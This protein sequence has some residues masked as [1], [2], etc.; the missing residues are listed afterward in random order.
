MTRESKLQSVSL[1]IESKVSDPAHEAWFRADVD[2]AIAEAD[3]PGAEW[4]SQEE[5]EAMSLKK[6]AER[7]AH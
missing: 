4:V 5:A 6:R 1:S 3:R 7:P 2:F